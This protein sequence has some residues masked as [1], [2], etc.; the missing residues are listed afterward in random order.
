MAHNYY[1]GYDVKFVS[2]LKSVTVS[3]YFPDSTL[4]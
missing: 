4:I 1:C 2:L 3:N